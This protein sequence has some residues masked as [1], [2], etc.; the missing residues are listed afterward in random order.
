MTDRENIKFAVVQEKTAGEF[1]SSVQQ[2][3]DDHVVHLVDYKFTVA[4]D[5]DGNM[6]YIATMLYCGDF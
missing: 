6:L 5:N 2:W 3:L 4:K 1:E